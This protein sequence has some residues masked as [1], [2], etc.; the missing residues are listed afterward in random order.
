MN[1]KQAPLVNKESAMVLH[2][3]VEK[4]L[5]EKNSEKIVSD[6][7]PLVKKLKFLIPTSSIPS[8]TPLNSIMPKP[9]Q[10]LD[11]TKMTIGQFTEH[12]SKT[13]SSIFSPSPPRE[14]TPPKDESKGKGI[15]AEEPLKDIMPFMKKG[16]SVP[17]IPSFKSLVIL[18]GQLTNEDVMDQVK[19]MK[20]L[21]DLKPEKEKSEKSLLK[22]MNPATIRGQALKMAEYEAKRKKM[23]DEYNH[24]I[25]HREV[26]VTE[27][28]VVDGMQR[29][30]IPPSGI[31]G[32]RGR[33]IKEPE[34]GIFY[35][36]GNFDLV[37][38]R[39]KEFHL[40]TTAQLMRLQGVI[41]RG[42]PEAEKMFKKME[43]TIEAINDTSSAGVEGL[44]ECKASARNLR[45]IQ[46]KDIVKE[47]EDHLKT[48]SSAGM[49]ISWV[50]TIPNDTINTTTTTNVA[51]TAVDENLPQLLDSRG[52]SH[53]TNVTEFDKEDFTS[54]KV[55]FLVF[56]DGLEPYL[57]KTLEDG[58]F[59]I[60]SDVEEDQRTS[61]EFIADLNAEYHE[62]D[63]LVQKRIDDLTKGKSEKGLIAESFDWDEESVSLEDE[64]T[65]KIRAFIA[66]AEDEPSVGKTCSKVTLDQL[67]SEH[68]PDNIVKALGGR[69]KRKDKISSKEVIFTKAD[70][71]SFMSIPEITSD[72][73]S[74]CETHEPLPR[75]PKVIGTTPA[76]TLDSLISLSNLTLNMAD[77]T[78]DTSVLKKTKPTSIKV[79]FGYEIKKKTK[80]KS[81]VVSKSCTNKKADSST[82]QLLFTLLEEVKGLKKQIK[83]PSGT[84]LSN[85]Q[86]S[87]SK[88]NKQKTWFGHCQHC[89]LRNHLS[90][91][92]YSKPKCSMMRNFF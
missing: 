60:D 9:I 92:S 8:P 32:S 73:E 85:S 30:L 40:A 59:D 55:R 28:I 45:R 54:W 91:D 49:D 21:V 66:I 82:E 13:T 43:M 86:S 46:V 67:L 71:S 48:Y 31:E 53:V 17:K 72:S 4:C 80:N 68:K 1:V 57:L 12:L 84:S 15:T 38:Q 89:G 23:L 64:G 5:E 61:N 56:L 50:D 7:E 88:S 22:I 87:S 36:N 76:G 79:S 14:P 11:V 24:Q 18:E 75:L 41:Q 44:A 10:N 90:D 34:S 25:S 27:N 29:N 19:E 35:Y 78:L 47:V 52:G 2:A 20:R 16:G 26:F 74:E 33:F 6:D 62:R 37:Y 69:G 3:L 81:P 70:E 39:E 51:Q 77:L 63:L 58:P 65:T 83:T 42:T